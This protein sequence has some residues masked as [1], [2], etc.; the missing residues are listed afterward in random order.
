MKVS[1]CYLY[2]LIDWKNGLQDVAEGAKK[3]CDW[4]TIY[5]PTAR[6]LMS[7]RLG[8]Q[9]ARDTN[10]T[11]CTSYLLKA[12][13]QR[14]N[15]N[16]FE[17]LQPLCLNTTTAA[18][19]SRRQL[20]PAEMLEKYRSLIIDGAGI[21]GDHPSSP[22][23][24]SSSEGGGQDPTVHVD[25]CVDSHTA[26]YLNDPAIQAVVTRGAP[27]VTWASCNP[28]LN[29]SITDTMISMIPVYQYIVANSSARLLVYSGDLDGV[30]PFVGTK[31]W[32]QGNLTGTTWN[33]T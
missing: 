31:N 19:Q 3:F 10:K 4:I 24:L 1:W 6:A 16:L 21:A 25:A 13:E 26:Q 15:I 5:D 22:D 11:L 20:K 32:I 29:Y 28:H 17:I 8:K 18:S 14:G 12:R 33:K 27:T 7:S 23:A 9:G 2:K 30:V